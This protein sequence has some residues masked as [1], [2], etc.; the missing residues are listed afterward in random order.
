MEPENNQ[1]RKEQDYE[2]NSCRTNHPPP[3]QNLPKTE[4]D[5]KFSYRSPLRAIVSLNK[6]KI[7]LLVIVVFLSTSFLFADCR[8]MALIGLNGNNLST[9]I[10]S[11]TESCLNQLEFQSMQGNDDGWGL[12]LYD[13]RDSTPL[14]DTLNVFRGSGAAYF[15]PLFSAAVDTIITHRTPR[16]LLGHVRNATD[17]D[18][19]IDNPHPFI[20]TYG[21]RDF[22]FVHNGT[23]EKGTILS[24]IRATEEGRAWLANHPLSPGFIDSEVYFSWIMFSIHRQQG[25]ILKG[26]HDAL[27]YIN[28]LSNTHHKNFILSDGVDLY[29]YKK[30]TV[31][32]TQHPL[33]Y[34]YYP[35]PG[36]RF[37][38]FMSE[39]PSHVHSTYQLDNNELVFISSTGNVIRMP[40]F[41][42]GQHNTGFTQRLAFHQGINWSGFPILPDGAQLSSLNHFVA[43]DKGGL[44]KV[45]YV[46]VSGDE[47]ST[48]YN[49]SGGWDPDPD[50]DP[51]KLYKL[52]FTSYSPSLHYGVAEFYICNASFVGQSDAILTDIEPYEEYWVS[53]TLLSSQNIKDAFGPAWR[54]VW[55]VRAED[56]YYEAM[57]ENPR[58]SIPIIPDSWSIKGK[59]MEFGKGYIIKF[60]RAL[61]QFV[62]HRSNAP[63]R[64]FKE[65]SMG[66]S[67]QWEEAPDYVVVDI[68][69][70]DNA[71]SV[72]EIG[73]KQNGVCV[74]AASIDEL[75]HQILIYP[76]YDNPAPLEFEIIY[77]SKA[78]PSYLQDYALLDETEYTFVADRIIP[79][80]DGIYFV[81][82]SR[83][84]ADNNF[85]PIA[86]V[87]N[88]TNY[89]NPFN[90]ST[91]ISFVLSKEAE[92]TVQI[93]NIKGQKVF[94][95][96]AK[97][98]PAGKTT[99]DWNGRDKSNG[100]V[101]SGIYFVRIK[102][103]DDSHTHK[104]IMMK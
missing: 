78:P 61:N 19:D 86:R 80:K 75:P 87:K 62:W 20:M 28:T 30:T 91:S 42:P 3:P 8:M 6:A 17:G 44:H 88:V 22:T 4:L 100:P 7:A 85:K 94:D 18:D 83:M 26:I 72:K 81:D 57:P 39:F 60:K 97:H 79:E 74:G 56:W 51:K 14:I 31:N 63:L 10:S 64:E 93:Y 47:Q 37:A 1:K 38:G 82:L 92:A 15:D 104:M 59:N 55:S 48:I 53:Y 103:N 95:F 34:H 102:T 45:D 71:D 67:F 46:N 33:A 65:R 52:H 41:S 70:V 69:D 23:V 13:Y 9:P 90:P 16:I 12:V 84:D 54:H 32:D 35:G 36:R 40:H 68:I 11:F 27:I 99:L 77:D 101:S 89:P 66:T 24:H 21:G 2:I 76:D 49:E 98:Y 5:S 73:V 58:G 96:G 50:L 43:A 25:D 29:G